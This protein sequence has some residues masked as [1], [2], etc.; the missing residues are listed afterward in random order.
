MHLVLIFCYQYFAFY[1]LTGEKKLIIKIKNYRQQ[2]YRKNDEILLL[3]DVDSNIS[4]Y[5]ME[6]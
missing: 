3:Q 5:Q 6:N 2:D 4:V 1:Y